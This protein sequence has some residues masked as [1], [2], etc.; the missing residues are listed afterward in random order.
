VRSTV[1]SAS[2]VIIEPHAVEAGFLGEHGGV[3]EV[4]PA[5]AKRVEQ[6]VHL[7]ATDRTGGAPLAMATTV[8]PDRDDRARDPDTVGTLGPGASVPGDR[9]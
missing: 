9:H 4:L 2:E 8:R 7:H 1:R 5:P 6:Q 3:A